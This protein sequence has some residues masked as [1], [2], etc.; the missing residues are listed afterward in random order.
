MIHSTIAHR[1][2]LVAVILA[3]AC[4]RDDFT[5]TQ[6]V[7]LIGQWARLRPDQKTWG[8]TI[9]LRANGAAVDPS[10]DV[11]PDSLRWS[12]VRSRVAGAGLCLGPSRKPHC[13]QYRLEGDTLVVGRIA[14]PTYYRR[15]H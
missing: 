7:E 8:D 1:L 6:P 9:E 2:T 5:V 12:V 14:A 15:A 10:R 11:S 4:H 3:S 13:Q